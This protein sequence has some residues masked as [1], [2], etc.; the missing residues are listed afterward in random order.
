MFRSQVQFVISDTCVG[1]QEFLT[2]SI[3]KDSTAAPAVA[4]E[5][6]TA[7]SGAVAGEAPP[8]PDGL[9]AVAESAAIPPMLAPQSEC[10]CASVVAWQHGSGGGGSLVA[11]GWRQR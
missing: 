5:V 4:G 3:R 2:N 8:T 7:A 11:A 10:D 6:P 9:P 1:Q